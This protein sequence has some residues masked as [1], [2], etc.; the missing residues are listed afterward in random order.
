ML[1]SF[2]VVGAQKSGTTS[3]HSYLQAYPNIFLP[4]Q[5]E[6]KFFVEDARYIKGMEYY[7]HQWFSDVAPGQLVGEVDPDYMYFDKALERIAGALDTRKIRFI[8]VFREPVSRAFSH[9]LMSHRRGI[10]PLDF[11][12]AIEDEP[13]RIRKGYYERLHYSY[14]DRGFYYRQVMRFL[15]RIDRKQVHFILSEDLAGNTEHVLAEVLQF[16][17][18]DEQVLPVDREKKHVATV[19]RNLRLTK[20]VISKG[21]H[22]SLFKV[23]MPFPSLRQ[24]L[25]QGILQWN[26]TDNIG[27]TLDVNT[28]SRLRAV[29]REENQNL[30]KLI[31][32]DLSH[33]NSD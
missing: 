27:I 16:L 28:R 18:V 23:L 30:S 25:R 3:L 1:P 20:A 7:Q 21:P 26:Q 10:E 9:Y 8:F 19:P 31:G 24:K 6:T 33:W 11:E 2:L 32:R 15:E 17:E 14:L 22:K 13:V 4:E 12:Q 29:Y 5:K